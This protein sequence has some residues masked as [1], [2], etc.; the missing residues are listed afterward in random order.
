MGDLPGHDF[1]GNQWTEG[2]SAAMDR[3]HDRMFDAFTRK[4]I[5]KR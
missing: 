2:Q 5:A 1:R 3:M 4:A